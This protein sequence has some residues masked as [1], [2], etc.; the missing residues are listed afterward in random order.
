[1]LGKVPLG[2]TEYSSGHKMPLGKLDSRLF[3][4]R[5]NSGT[6][7]FVRDKNWGTPKT[8]LYPSQDDLG[9]ALSNTPVKDLQWFV[10]NPT[11]TM[12]TN[13]LVWCDETVPPLVALSGLNGGNCGAPTF[14]L[15]TDPTKIQSG[16]KSIKVVMSAGTWLRSGAKFDLGA[17]T[18][19][20][21]KDIVSFYLLGNNDGS[22]FLIVLQDSAGNAASYRS[23]TVDNWTG[24]KK[25]T[26]FLGTGWTQYGATPMNLNTIRY[27][28]IL[29]DNNAKTW[30][31]DRGTFDVAPS[32]L[33]RKATL[34]F[35]LENAQEESSSAV[36]LA[37][38]D[39][40]MSF[41]T[42]WNNNVISN[43]ATTL[44][45]TKQSL[46]MVITANT[47]NSGVYHV[48]GSNQDFSAF[49]FVCF[50]FIG[51]NSG[52]TW[53]FALS[54]DSSANPYTGNGYGYNF[55]DNFTG[56]RRFV[57]PI[58]AMTVFGSPTLA[59]IRKVMLKITTVPASG[60]WYIGRSLRDVGQW[61]F[62]EV[63]VPDV[64]ATFRNYVKPLFA[65]ALDMK[66]WNLLFWNGSSYVQC[67]GPYEGGTY[68][69]MMWWSQLSRFLDA[70]T[71]KAIYQTDDSLVTNCATAF[72]EG[73]CGQTKTRKST[74]MANQNI[75]YN[76]SGTKNMVGFA[77]K[78]PP[79][80]FT[81]SP[82][83]G[84]SQCRLKLEMYSP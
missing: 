34:E 2:K 27:I 63:G 30:W 25:F 35:Y 46:K 70:T 82:T 59:T 42:A 83:A 79:P 17:D 31:V 9:F 49:D 71:F 4:I 6:Q 60:T 16:T 48:Y 26:F 76:L 78:M 67:M 73:F 61:A 58:K 44:I 23:F 21:S 22:N 7:V 77:V 52:Y 13:P 75:T 41:W 40:Q 10:R 45:K 15:E 5:V 8:M 53:Q 56:L 50:Y 51:A 81:Q 11:S 37:D 36:V 84:I 74:D 64:L 39:D 12:E 62:V 14:S 19:I 28:W 33:T 29:N 3:S 32:T 47:D 68:T 55:T 20:S 54:S 80:D 24:L 1:M 72:I 65:S 66:Y 18:N 69:F 38:G 57:V 43:D